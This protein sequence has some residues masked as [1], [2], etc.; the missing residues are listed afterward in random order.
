MQAHEAT[1]LLLLFLSRRR[2]E[3]VSICTR[4]SKMKKNW[5]ERSRS[6]KLTLVPV[7]LLYTVLV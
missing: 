1:N 2:E 3:H 6:K 5:Q 4:V 7:P